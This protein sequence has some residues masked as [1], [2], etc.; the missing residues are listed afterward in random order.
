MIRADELMLGD[1]V[2]VEGIPRQVE[3]ITKKKIG[4]HKDKQKDGRLYYARLCEIEPIDLTNALLEKNFAQ[5]ATPN[6]FQVQIGINDIVLDMRRLGYC[7]LRVDDAIF[8]SEPS[9][10]VCI[11]DSL[12]ILQNALRTCNIEIDWKF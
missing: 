7:F 9:M 3:A 8:V 6:H 2:S 4:Y 11:E 10:D 12:H 1:W 5:G